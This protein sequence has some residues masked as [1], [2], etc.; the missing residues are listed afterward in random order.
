MSSLGSFLLPAMPIPAVGPAAA[1]ARLVV[2]KCHVVVKDSS[3]IFTT[4]KD[5]E[6][7]KSVLSTHGHNTQNLLMQSSEIIFSM[8]RS[9]NFDK[10]NSK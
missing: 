8:R 3:V 9:Y 10:S 2:R 4:I 5:D 6:F 7:T 1:V